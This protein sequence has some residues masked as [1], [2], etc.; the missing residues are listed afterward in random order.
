MY[1]LRGQ[2]VQ[3]DDGRV[4]DGGEDVRVQVEHWKSSRLL[5]VLPLL[6]AVLDRRARAVRLKAGWHPGSCPAAA[7][8][9]AGQADV[10]EEM[11]LQPRELARRTVAGIAFHQRTPHVGETGAA[12]VDWHRQDR[13][14]PVGGGLRKGPSGHGFTFVF[15]FTSCRL[16]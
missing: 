9:V 1:A 16:G 12:P 6:A 8:I 2:R 13:G 14:D 3:A 5:W 4:A 15:G 10:A 11:I 7:D